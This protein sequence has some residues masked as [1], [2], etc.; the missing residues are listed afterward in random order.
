MVSGE[1]YRLL[2]KEDCEKIHE[3]TVKVLEDTGLRVKSRKAI[4][5]F[6]GGG[7]K[8]KQ[9][10]VKIPREILEDCIRKAPEKVILYSRDGK[11]NL[12]VENRN[13]FF[14]NVGGCIETYDLETGK[15]RE[16]RKKD[17]ANFAKL[18]DYLEEIDL[19][20]IAC[21]PNDV[22]QRIWDRYSWQAAFENTTKHIMGSLIGEAGAKD[23]I[24][25]VS[26]I[27]GEEAG[28]KPIFSVVCC[29][30]SPL[31]I[32][33]ENAEVLIELAK[34]N[35][36]IMSSVMSF[37]GSS[38]PMTLEGTIVSTNAE[39]LSQVVLT[40]LVSQGAPVFYGCVSTSMDMRYATPI[41]GGPEMGLINAACGEMAKYYK[42]PYYGTGGLTD[43]KE[44][45]FQSGA[46]RTL[47]ALLPALEG[48]NLVH[49]M[50]GAL[51]SLLIVSYEQMVL[52][53]ELIKYIRRILKGVDLKWDNFAVDVINKVGPGGNFLSQPH[54][55]QH[56]MEALMPDLF[57][58]RSWSKW[59][60]DK[61]DIV[62]KAREKGKQILDTHLPEP[63]P[64]ETSKKL[65]KIIK[66]AKR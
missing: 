39:T 32:M 21:I 25:M 31:T 50:G 8:V 27:T 40:E 26:G 60:A 4:S 45:D 20:H 6:E 61:K 5:I 1:Y 42:L 29:L 51:D 34:H 57:E 35:I 33:K 28:R 58:R 43:S 7:C 14:S 64:E 16:T 36:P 37:M 53:N 47:T 65:N 2:T 19:Y 46:E 38:A 11:N 41:T 49:T 44:V 12:T 13:V 48:A 52:D 56:R 54:T 55:R 9:N 24:K 63:L 17:V 22:D 18:V 3:A 30:Q 62:E 23:L 59:K 15:K 10:I 66:E